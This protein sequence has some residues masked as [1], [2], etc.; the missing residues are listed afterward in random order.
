MDYSVCNHTRDKQIGPI[1]LNRSY[2]TPLSPIT[3]ICTPIEIYLILYWSHAY[4]QTFLCMC[5]YWSRAQSIKNGTRFLGL[6]LQRTNFTCLFYRLNNS[7]RRNWRKQPSRTNVSVI[8]LALVPE[9]INKK[10]VK[11]CVILID[12]H[13]MWTMK[14]YF[15]EEQTL[16]EIQPIRKWYKMAAAWYATRTVNPPLR[17][18][19]R[20]NENCSLNEGTCITVQRLYER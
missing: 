13:Q 12:K 2:W 16:R 17:G 15:Y 9:I 8:C 10:C 14:L 5:C 4:S 1:L 3:I 6:H 11:V 19:P 20:D 18:H 7:T